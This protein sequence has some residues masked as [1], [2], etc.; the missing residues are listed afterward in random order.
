[1]NWIPAGFG[2]LA[3]AV[4]FTTALFPHWNVRWGRHGKGP[5]MTMVGRISLGIYF[6]CWS[7]RCAFGLKSVWGWALFIIAFIVWCDGWRD[8]RIHENAARK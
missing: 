3:A 2:L 4:A 8:Q 6:V 1:M 7:V 5:P